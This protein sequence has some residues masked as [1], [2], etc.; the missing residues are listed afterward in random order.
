MNP[1]LKQFATFNWT[2]G[3]ATIAIIKDGPGTFHTAYTHLNENGNFP[4]SADSSLSYW[5]YD[6]SS[7]ATGALILGQYANTALNP[8][9]PDRNFEKFDI[10][11]SNGL[12]IKLNTGGTSLGSVTV[13]FS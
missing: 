3:G 6:N 12:V 7:T 13:V 1:K 8:L 5:L 11:F 10:D 4:R 2:A 9:E